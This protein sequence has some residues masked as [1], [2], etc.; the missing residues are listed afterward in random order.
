[1]RG[2]TAFVER[3][4]TPPVALPGL[5]TTALIGDPEGG[6]GLHHAAV[7]QVGPRF[8]RRWRG[9]DRQ[10]VGDLPRRAIG[11]RELPAEH[12]PVACQG[13]RSDLVVA[14]Q[15][16]GRDAHRP[17]PSSSVATPLSGAPARSWAG[18]RRA[19]TPPARRVATARPPKRSKAR[20]RLPPSTTTSGAKALMVGPNASARFAPKRW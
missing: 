19:L 3:F 18:S 5:K 2:G 7:P 9:R 10:P 6:R 20:V 16:R 17:A 14:A 1:G 4:D 15:G 12:G 11:G 8:Q 13:Q